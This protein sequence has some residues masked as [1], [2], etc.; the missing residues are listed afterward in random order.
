M[1]VMYVWTAE[2]GSWG[3]ASLSLNDNSAYISWWPTGDK[4]K[5]SLK[6]RKSDGKT[7]DHLPV[8]CEDDRDHFTGRHYTHRFSIGNG[9]IDVEKIRKW[10]QKIK[11]DGGYHLLFNNCCDLVVQA[12][13][14]GG[15]EIRKSLIRKPEDMFGLGRDLE[16]N[17]FTIKVYI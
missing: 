17:D 10:W 15:L 2:K 8:N 4:S 14:E 5:N 11:D 13:R 1:A 9:V 16:K 3:H 7:K 6:K 12:L